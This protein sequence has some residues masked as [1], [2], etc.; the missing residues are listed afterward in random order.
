MALLRHSTWDGVARE[1]ISRGCLWLGLICLALASAPLATAETTEAKEFQL[2]SVF[3]F[4][5]TQFVDWPPA[6]FS[7]PNSPLVI[8]ILGDDPFGNALDEAVRGEKVNNR[9]LIVHRY[10]RLDEI[11]DCQILYVSVSKPEEL[12]RVLSSLKGRSILTVGDEDGFN[13][14]GGMIRF[15]NENNR[16][17]LRINLGEAR[18]AGLTISSKL[19]RPAEI[20][21][22]KGEA[23]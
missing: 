19:L 8:G 5:F 6:A 11:A 1:S 21:T 13:R 7:Q 15:V 17:R 23:P 20:V 12:Q 9:P 14:M 22:T 2:K 4:Y 10:K 16:I 18:A 3:L